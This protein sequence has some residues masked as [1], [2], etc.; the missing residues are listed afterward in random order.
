MTPLPEPY[1]T[2]LPELRAQ[3]DLQALLAESHAVFATGRDFVIY[4]LAKVAEAP[5]R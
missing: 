5:H 4:D 1:A 3:S 2:H